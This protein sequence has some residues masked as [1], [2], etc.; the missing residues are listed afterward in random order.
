MNPK[1]RH[2]TE[3][4]QRE[5]HENLAAKRVVVVQDTTA[6]GSKGR[7]VA[8][9]DTSFTSGDDQSVLDVSTDLGRV[10]TDGTFVNDGEGNIKIEISD[11]GSNYGGI[12]TIK[13][14]EV[15]R[16]DGLVIS[17]IRLT[18]VAD[19]SYRALIL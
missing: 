10:G 8:Y 16:F 12:H 3:I 9:E 17:K 11:D 19:S 4:A 1:T 6:G 15:M 5:H 2:K 13:K 7:T 18:Y 14:D